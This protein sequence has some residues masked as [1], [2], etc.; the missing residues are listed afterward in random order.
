MMLRCIRDHKLCI[1][2]YQPIS[3]SSCCLRQ[4]EQSGNGLVEWMTG[5]TA[6]LGNEGMLCR[7]AVT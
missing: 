2:S 1:G 5:Q 3:L 7:Y 6:I 4:V